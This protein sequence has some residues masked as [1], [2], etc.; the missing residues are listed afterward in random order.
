[1]RRQ[2]FGVACL[3]ALCAACVP[4]IWEDDGPRQARID[5]E[6]RDQL[7]AAGVQPLPKPR[8]LAMDHPQVVLGQALFFD[9]ILS[10]NEDIACSTCHHPRLGTTDALPL[11]I[12]VGGDGLGPQRQM[13]RGREFVPRNAPDL[14][15]RNL[16]QWETMFWDNRVSGYDG[17][18]QTPA[19]DALPPEV[20]TPLAAQSMFPP[21]S[22]DEMRGKP[23]ENPI[24]DAES[25]PEIWALLTER[26]MNTEAYLPLVDAAFPGVAPQ[27]IHFGH[28]GIAMAE[29]EATAF[30]TLNTPF[31]R[32]LAGDNDAMTAAQKRGAMLFFGTARCGDCHSGALL[33]DQQTH[34]LGVPQLGPGKGDE[35]PMDHGRY[36]E[37][38][39]DADMFAFRTP[40]LRNVALTGPYMHDGAFASLRAAV[41][42]HLNPAASLQNYDP[43]QLP[44]AL[45]DTVQL[46][47]GTIA[48][49]LAFIDPDLQ[50]VT[51]TDEQLDDLMAFLAEAL[52]DP[53]A[54]HLDHTIPDAVP[55]G[56]PVDR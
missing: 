23:G 18:L 7:D 14:F 37:S 25:V 46:D 9:P 52:T 41:L 11:P 45:R 44:P 36:R 24:A 19:D 6:L 35:S 31:D 32:Y 27:D 22:A 43:H 54:L 30:T 38:G 55:S 2:I 56:L 26:V 15:N 49:K 5:V 42:H 48:L 16:P 20:T 39:D 10:G 21:T 50:A 29:F 3:T 1:M 53:A 12:G 33:S 34:A 51:L 8:L 28:F 13:G 17:R 47:E 4:S 40:M